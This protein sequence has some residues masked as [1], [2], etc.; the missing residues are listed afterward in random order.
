MNFDFGGFCSPAR[1]GSD[2]DQGLLSIFNSKGWK[3]EPDKQSRADKTSPRRLDAKLPAR[4]SSLADVKEVGVKDSKDPAAACR[5]EAALNDTTHSLSKAK[6]YVKT[7]KEELRTLQENSTTEP[8][9]GVGSA[10]SNNAPIGLGLFQAFTPA[11]AGAVQEKPDEAA[12]SKAKVRAHRLQ[13]VQSDV[14]RTFKFDVC[15]IKFSRNQ[16]CHVNRAVPIQLYGTELLPYSCIG[17]V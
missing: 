8:P 15:H 10:S 2:E 1:K 16:Y 17:A 4:K 13:A 5:T 3:L 11:A 9:K 14:L 6:E 7:A 12:K